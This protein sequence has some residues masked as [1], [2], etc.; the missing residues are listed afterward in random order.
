MPKTARAK[1]RKA[2]PVKYVFPCPFAPPS[3]HTCKD[4]K[5]CGPGTSFKSI[6]KLN[7]HL[8]RVHSLEY[9]CTR[10]KKHKY[11]I[12]PSKTLKN[13]KKVHEEEECEGEGVAPANVGGQ[14]TNGRAVGDNV[15]GA[16]NNDNEVAVDVRMTEE[17][18]NRWKKW[19]EMGV[20]EIKGE[21]KPQTSWRRIGK[22]L[23]HDGRT[24][25]NASTLHHDAIGSSDDDDGDEDEEEEEEEEEGERRGD[26]AVPEPTIMISYHDNH[27]R[28]DGVFDGMR[29]AH[30]SQASDLASQDGTVLSWRNEVGTIMQE[31]PSPMTYATSHTTTN[32]TW[33]PPQSNYFNSFL[34]EPAQLGATS[35]GVV[36]SP[37]PYHDFNL[38]YNGTDAFQQG[39]SSKTR[40]DIGVFGTGQLFPNQQGPVDQGQLDGDGDPSFDSNY[41]LHLRGRP[42]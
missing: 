18:E 10:C 4:K 27:H 22:S 24:S 35:P 13:L 20:S 21:P 40:D 19:K 41:N 3:G 30:Y 2:P 15:H 6:E 17:Q 14:A 38:G 36:A 23:S 9:I 37:R 34:F 31:G 12:V 26:D 11:A 33:P 7:E 39:A 29:A 8:K 25:P 16:K 32:I 5:R 28:D 1:I 42:T